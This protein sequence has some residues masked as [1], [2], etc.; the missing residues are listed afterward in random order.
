MSNDKVTALR[1][2]IHGE[3]TGDDMAPYGSGHVRPL[4]DEIRM[5]FM[6]RQGKRGGPTQWEKA[7]FEDRESTLNELLDPELADN[8][9]LDDLM[10]DFSDSRLTFDQLNLV[11]KSN[12]NYK[13]S[14]KSLDEMLGRTATLV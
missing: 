9:S 13:E 4:D 1:A 11:K 7:F 12:Q 2:E 14:K 5:P 6:I 3:V 8:T 10:E